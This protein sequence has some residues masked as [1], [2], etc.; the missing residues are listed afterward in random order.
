MHTR[1]AFPVY[2][3]LD[4]EKTLPFARPNSTHTDCLCRHSLPYRSPSTMNSKSKIG[5][6]QQNLDKIEEIS[7]STMNYPLGSG[8]C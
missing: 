6:V 3:L 8:K 5:N 7:P 2:T 1:I 4:R